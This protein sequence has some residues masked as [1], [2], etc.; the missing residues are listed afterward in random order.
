VEEEN[1]DAKRV[2]RVID[3]IRE[4]DVTPNDLRS[5]FDSWI[6]KKRSKLFIDAVERIRLYSKQ[7]VKLCA[8]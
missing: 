3:L 7:P 2:Y 4:H 6:E 8:Q 5:L 1:Q